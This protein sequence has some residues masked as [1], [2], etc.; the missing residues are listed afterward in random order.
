MG[1]G[2]GGGGVFTMT[3]L[4]LPDPLTGRYSDN[5][6]APSLCAYKN[7][8]GQQKDQEMFE[9]IHLVCVSVGAHACMLVCHGASVC[10]SVLW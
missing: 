4:H 7:A 6:F 8:D 9:V 2:G 1:G 10:V 3:E 5:T